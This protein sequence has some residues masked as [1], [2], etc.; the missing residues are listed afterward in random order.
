MHRVTS[1][2]V[3]TFTWL[4]FR[5]K[6]EEEKSQLFFGKL[7]IFLQ[8]QV[9]SQADGCPA[10]SLS[11]KLAMK[12]SDQNLYC[13]NIFEWGTKSESGA[14]KILCSSAT[15]LPPPILLNLG[16]WVV[17]FDRSRNKL[18]PP[19]PA[20]TKWIITMGRRSHLWI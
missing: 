10:P 19:P 15:Y 12:A 6:G 18:L 13:G 2:R 11:P 7:S 4:A 9:H 1:P 20:L 8:V 3:G 17:T 5:R 16:S 14:P